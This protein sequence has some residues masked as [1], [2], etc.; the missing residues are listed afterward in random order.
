MVHSLNTT[1]HAAVLDEITFIIGNS[2][3][4][5]QRLQTPKSTSFSLAVISSIIEYL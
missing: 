3:N 5:E 1:P 2:E 4:I